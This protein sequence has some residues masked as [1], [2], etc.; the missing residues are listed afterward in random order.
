MQ[1]FDYSKFADCGTSNMGTNKFATPEST[2]DVEDLAV[3]FVRYVGGLSLELE[4]SWASNTAQEYNYVE[5]YGTKGGLK[6]EKGQLTLFEDF[7]GSVIDA[8]PKLK[9][10]GAWGNT[11]TRHFVDCILNDR[12]VMSKPE[13]AVKVMQIIRGIYQSAEAGG[14][15]RVG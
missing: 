4:F 3:G 1:W 11:E 9:A 2:Y 13:E 14:E 5:L 7:D 15:V 10:D 8:S 12:E 6:Y